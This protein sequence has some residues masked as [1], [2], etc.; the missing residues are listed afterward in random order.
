MSHY[1]LSAFA[2]EA[3]ETLA[4]QIA[5]LRRNGI[6]RLEIRSV[7]GVNICD[8]PLETVAEYRRQLDAAGIRVVTVGSK[9]GKIGLA[10]DWNAH[11]ALFLH[12]LAAAKLL[13]AE[14]IRMFSLFT[15]GQPRRC[16]ETVMARMEELLRMAEAAGIRLCHENEKD[17]YG[18]EGSRV[19][20]LMDRFAGRMEFIFDP[21]NFIQ[22][23]CRPP[24]MY[25]AMKNRIGYFHVKDCCAATGYVVPAGEGDGHL[26]EILAD[27]AKDHESTM[28][29]VEPHLMAF[30]GLRDDVSIR[31]DAAPRFA[32]ND[33]AFDYAVGALKT[34]LDRKGLSYE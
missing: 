15:G 30:T 34:I 16:R 4:A 10:D 17:I 1:I 19:L 5:A 28:L 3:G 23:G 32:D 11:T 21:A 14:K 27:Y 9:I 6:R 12:T 8:T 29:T 25:A 31:D 13:G 22:C 18:D 33:A 26:A 24:E 2:D 20:E 7:G